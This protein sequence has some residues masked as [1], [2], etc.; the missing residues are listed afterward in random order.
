[1][2]I[3]TQRIILYAALTVEYI[4]GIHY[5]SIHCFTQETKLQAV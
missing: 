5:L 3:T 1:M 4:K 2:L